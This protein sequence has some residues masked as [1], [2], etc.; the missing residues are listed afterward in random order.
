MDNKVTNFHGY[1]D[2][3]TPYIAVPSLADKALKDGAGN[4]ISERYATKD[5]VAGAGHE[6]ASFTLTA[7]GWTVSSPSNQSITVPW[8]LGADDLILIDAVPS[9]KR[10][11]I[12]AV[13]Y[14]SAQ[15]GSTVTMSCE[16]VPEQDIQITV[17]RFGR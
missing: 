8:T 12:N 1:E 6:T 14:C 16:A 11:A 15:S 9:S 13:L 7:G 4:V 2:D 17:T 5:E 10:N 3:G